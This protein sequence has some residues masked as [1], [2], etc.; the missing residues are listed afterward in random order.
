[1]K[2]RF[3]IGDRFQQTEA[4]S[5][6]G[7]W[8]TTIVA[9]SP[10][11]N[12]KGEYHYLCLDVYPEGHMHKHSHFQSYDDVP[13]EEPHWEYMGNYPLSMAKM[14]ILPAIREL[15]ELARETKPEAPL[16]LFVIPIW[17]WH[18]NCDVAEEPFDYVVAATSMELAKEIAMKE[19][20]KSEWATPS[21]RVED[22][23]CLYV[24]EAI[25]ADGPYA[26]TLTKLGEKPSE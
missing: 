17:D 3:N 14:Y 2:P 5:L 20:K 9:V 6:T 4:V 10:I 25:G 24:Q 12:D 26:I 18:N 15:I 1:M 22:N 13:V 7:G 21:A 23:D 8:Q 19:H 16:Q 11:P